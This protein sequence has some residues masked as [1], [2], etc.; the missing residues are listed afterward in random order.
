MTSVI[1]LTSFTGEVLYMDYDLWKTGWYDTQADIDYDEFCSHNH[2]ANR[3]GI[4]ELLEELYSAS[5][6]NLDFIQ[7][8]LESL[9]IDYG[10]DF[11]FDRTLNLQ[12]SPEI[13]LSTS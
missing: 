13:P 12:R 10:V 7:E 8:Q 1:I 5:N 11:N 6:L 9:A 3:V 2:Q 4:E